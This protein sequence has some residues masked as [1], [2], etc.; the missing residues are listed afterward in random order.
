MVFFLA[1]IEAACSSKVVVV[2][3]LSVTKRVLALTAT[4]DDT[5]TTTT[6]ASIGLQGEKQ[7]RRQRSFIAR[8]LRRCF[9]SQARASVAPISLKLRRIPPP[10]MSRQQQDGGCLVRHLITPT[11]GRCTHTVKV[12]LAAQLSCSKHPYCSKETS[13]ATRYTD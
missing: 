8:K 7:R 6:V 4:M 5:S 1:V 12:W 13:L 10:Q 2:L 9:A 11:F 3:L